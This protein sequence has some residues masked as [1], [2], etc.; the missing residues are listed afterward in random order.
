MPYEA[1][2]MEADEIN[3]CFEYNDISFD[4]SRRN[5]EN[6]FYTASGYSKQAGLELVNDSYIAI[7]ELI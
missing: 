3:L 4:G 7:N 6:H 2:G 1:L 5:V